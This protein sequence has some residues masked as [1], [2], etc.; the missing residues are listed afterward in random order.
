M[1]LMTFDVTGI[2]GVEP[3]RW[4]EIIGPGQDADA[5]A[6]MA[7]TIG[8]E[9]LTSLGRRFRRDYTPA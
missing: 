7:G 6:D 5:V 1:D 4:I 9:L 8:Y 3:G 2:K